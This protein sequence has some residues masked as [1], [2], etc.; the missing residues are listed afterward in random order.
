M[1]F[2]DFV[3]SLRISD[4]DIFN[5]KNLNFIILFRILSVWDTGM[6]W[7]ERPKDTK[8]EV[9]IPEGPP[10]RSRGLESS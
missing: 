10:A 8:E 3:E 2:S 7:P 5:K 6:A 9:K 4:F 1:K